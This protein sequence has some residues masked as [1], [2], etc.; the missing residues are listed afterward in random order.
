APATGANAGVVRMR[1]PGVGPKFHDAYVLELPCGKHTVVARSI[2]DDY[3][4]VRRRRRRG[5]QRLEAAG[6]IRASVERHDD[7]RDIKH[8][9]AP[10]ACRRPR[11]SSCT[12][13]APQAPLTGRARASLRRTGGIRGRAACRGRRQTAT[14]TPPP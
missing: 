5:V 8:V 1:E 11:G 10:S 2:V 7:D 9:R 12:W 13:Q 6:E 3:D 14:T 4:L